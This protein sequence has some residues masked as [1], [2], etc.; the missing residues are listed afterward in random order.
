MSI[1]TGI[2]ALW[3]AS[4]PLVMEFGNM[5][6]AVLKFD[7]AYAKASNGSC[8]ISGVE[9]AVAFPARIK[10][11]FCSLAQ[12][13]RHCSFKASSHTRTRAVSTKYSNVINI[14]VLFRSL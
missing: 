13:A 5:G 1:Y 3:H 4:A 2:K 6:C 8:A 14:F 9:A 10:H 7:L 12:C 11:D